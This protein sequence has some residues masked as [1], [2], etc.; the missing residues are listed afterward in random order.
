M[1]LESLKD[2]LHRLKARFETI[3]RREEH[4]AQLKQR[5]KE[6][7]EEI[8]RKDLVSLEWQVEDLEKLQ[9]EQVA[10]IQAED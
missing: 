10:R 2:A 1:L 9:H 5:R 3:K 8:R 7:K 4:I 6:L